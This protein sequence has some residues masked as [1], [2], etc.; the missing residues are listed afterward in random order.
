MDL[1]M[2]NSLYFFLW[3]FLT[4][5]VVDKN[6]TRKYQIFTKTEPFHKFC[7]D[8]RDNNGFSYTPNRGVIGKEKFM[9]FLFKFFDNKD[10]E[11]QV[12]RKKYWNCISEMP[13]DYPD[14]TKISEVDGLI[15]HIEKFIN[16]YKEAS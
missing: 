14:I 6:M 12:M 5:T 1:Y 9:E 10:I 7:Y 11:L 15:D 4:I 2:N 16:N 3:N 8:L 13:V